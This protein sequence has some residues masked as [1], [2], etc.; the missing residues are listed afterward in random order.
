MLCTGAMANLRFDGEFAEH[1][2]IAEELS[3]R[4]SAEVVRY[5]CV[6]SLKASWVSL[7][8]AV[9]TA[10]GG[11][12]KCNRVI[13]KGANVGHRDIEEHFDGVLYSYAFETDVVETAMRNLIRLAWVIAGA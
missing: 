9:G 13:G 3:R 7:D 4:A 8:A 2:G 10:R 11:L 1:L 5:I 6:S 12:S